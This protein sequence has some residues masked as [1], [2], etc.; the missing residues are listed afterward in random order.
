MTYS[1][2]IE[3]LIQH[4]DSLIAKLAA[5]DA[6]IE[7]LQ[8]AADYACR[9]LDIQKAMLDSRDAEIAELRKDSVR[10]DH[11]ET[12]C[13]AYGFQDIHEGNRWSIEGPFA[14]LRMA[15]DADIAIARQGEKHDNE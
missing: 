2:K 4:R 10:I 8:R 6:A 9:E 5:R 12:Q 15:I 3:D 13:T 7:K 11:M 14:T 1:A